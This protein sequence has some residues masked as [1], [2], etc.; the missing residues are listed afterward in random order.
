VLLGVVSVLLR[1]IAY[2]FGKR[3]PAEAGLQIGHSVSEV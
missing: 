2:L 3:T 1:L